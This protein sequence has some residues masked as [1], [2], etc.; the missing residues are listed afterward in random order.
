MTAG[1]WA[2]AYAG[3]R[4]PHLFIVDSLF[5]LPFGI[6]LEVLILLLSLPGWIS[7]VQKFGGMDGVRDG[8]SIV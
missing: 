1:L 7:H 2:M 4:I 5:C 8:G 3:M 6:L